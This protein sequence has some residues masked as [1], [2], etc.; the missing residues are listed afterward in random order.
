MK[1]IRSGKSSL[2]HAGGLGVTI[3]ASAEFGLPNLEEFNV[4]KGEITFTFSS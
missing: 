2:L 4:T 1:K 3:L